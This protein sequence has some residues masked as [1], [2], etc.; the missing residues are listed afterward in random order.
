MLGVGLHAVHQLG[1]GAWIGTLFLVV[2]AGYGGTRDL[3]ESERHPLIAALVHA[4]SPVA[5]AGVTT[6]VLAGVAL[7]LGSIEP[8]SALWSTG[9]GRTLLLK[10]LLLGGTAAIGAYNW[11]RVR[12]RLGHEEST[13]RLYRSATLEL[14]L[15][16]LLL[17][18]TAILVALPA[19]GLE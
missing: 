6:A 8:V 9:Y 2:A 15:G 1:G 5:L 3:P 10:L 16:A 18:A 7:A 13:G 14:I 17:G 19:P 4:Y 12:P 11:R